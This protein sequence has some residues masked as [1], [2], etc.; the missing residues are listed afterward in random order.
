DVSFSY[1]P[2]TGNILSGLTFT[3]EAGTFLCM[4]GANGSGKSTVSML[5]NGLLVPTSGSV[6]VD[7]MDTRDKNNR[8]EIRRRVGLL[9]QNPDN[10]IVGDT[11]EDDIAFGPENLGLEEDEIT[12]RVEKALLF[13]GLME[14]RYLSPSSLSGGEKAKLGIAG[15]LALNPEV[16]V[17]D[18]ATAMLDPKGRKDVLSL[19]HR[20]N[21]EHGK[22]IILITHHSDETM[23]AGRIMV[24]DGG[25]IVF[26]GEKRD[27]YRNAGRLKEMGVVLPPYVELS[28]CLKEKGIDIDPDTFDA[29]T[30]L[31]KL[32]GHNA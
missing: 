7:G 20:L 8:Y 16:L 5:L 15:L 6:L 30:L 19:L 4:T 13:S 28:L 9:F 27:V 24:I 11:V 21:K 26:D 17:L 31:E 10:Q 1:S 32:G 14:K 25:K 12:E 2:S 3:V 23:D 29:E 22:T 18:E